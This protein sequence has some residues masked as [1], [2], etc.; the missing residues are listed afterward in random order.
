MVGP[1]DV[2][3]ES[4][5]QRDDWQGDPEPATALVLTSRSE[6]GAADACA[7]RLTAADPAEENVLVV[8]Y[9]QLVDDVLDRWRDV[10]GAMPAAFGLISFAESTRSAAR[11]PSTPTSLPGSNVTLTAM[12]DP[13]DLQ[14]LGTA[15]TLYLDDWAD[16]GRR[17][18]VC[19]DSLTPML[20]ERGTEQVF[21]FLH[22]LTGY[23]KRAD[24]CT[25]PPRPN[26]TR[27]PD[28]KDARA[29]VRRRLWVR[30]GR[31][32]RA[33]VG[34]GRR[35]RRRSQSAAALHPRVPLRSRE[36]GRTARAR[37]RRRRHRERRRGRRSH[38]VRVRPGV[39]G[40]GGLTPP[41]VTERRPRGVR[42][43]RERG[44]P[45]AGGEAESTAQ[46]VRRRVLRVTAA[47]PRTTGRSAVRRRW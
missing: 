18:V 9:T 41:A 39:H 35:T 46:A 10:S 24:A 4:T 3:D 40:A 2:D 15:I 27:R 19:V 31:R 30:D 7:H 23:V 25:R 37:R 1:N 47:T 33:V 11:S 17:T 14:G 45:L 38:V 42:H 43:R 20:R 16:D 21:Q 28:D 29:A 34:R 44:D 36:P 8:T 5:G 32:G 6:L 13:G 22:V 26:P 12:N